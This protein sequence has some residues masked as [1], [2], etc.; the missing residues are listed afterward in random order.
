MN[1]TPLALL[2]LA[3]AAA[4]TPAYAG[5]VDVSRAHVQ[6]QLEAARSA[7]GRLQTHVDRF[8]NAFCDRLKVDV[9]I[10]H[11]ALLN[12]EYQVYHGNQDPESSRV[13]M[14]RVL[15][16]FEAARSAIDRMKWVAA[17]Q[18]EYWVRRVTIDVGIV[19]D[20]VTN[21][22]N[23]AQN[24]ARQQAAEAAKAKAEAAAK[25]RAD[26]KPTRGATLGAKSAPRAPTAA[27][28]PAKL[29]SRWTLSPNASRF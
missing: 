6:H 23:H 4:A 8:C 3:L 24:M 1:R 25:R 12:F 26:D 21:L 11:D 18:D 20:V 14:A 7:Q 22:E 10:V 13:T 29:P 9:G 27:P 19:A 17:R 15:H 28:S 16:Q 2:P 5:T